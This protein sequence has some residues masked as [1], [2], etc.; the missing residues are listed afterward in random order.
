MPLLH[1]KPR[2]KEV[3]VQLHA[4]L[5]WTLHGSD[6]FYSYGKDQWLSPDWG[7]GVCRHEK[8]QNLN[9]DREARSLV[10]TV[11]YLVNCNNKI[12][13]FLQT[14]WKTREKRIILRAGIMALSLLRCL[15][16]HNDI[17]VTTA[18]EQFTMNIGIQFNTF[19]N[20]FWDAMNTSLAFLMISTQWI[21]VSM[22]SVCDLITSH[23]LCKHLRYYYSSLDRYRQ[24]RRY[25]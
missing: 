7:F 11:N 8:N 18:K 22:C 4:F 14:T 1:C 5:A 21:Q 25:Q 24:R 20:K 3:V 13:F 6:L 17:R 23:N 15:K 2:H 12:C 10:T 9:P 19:Q 16:W